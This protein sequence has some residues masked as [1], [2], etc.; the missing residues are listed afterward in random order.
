MASKGPGPLSIL[1]LLPWW[2][3]A[4]MTLLSWVIL[5]GAAGREVRLPLE[6]PRFHSE[7]LL[8]AKQCRTLRRRATGGAGALRFGEASV[9]SGAVGSAAVGSERRSRRAQFAGVPK[10]SFFYG[11]IYH[12]L[13]R[14]INA[15]NERF[16]RFPVAP[17]S[18]EIMQYSIYDSK[19]LGTYNWHEDVGFHS[20]TVARV[21]SVSV[22]VSS[23]ESYD[24][25]ELQLRYG[26]RVVNASKEVG[27]A[28]IFPSH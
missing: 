11:Q 20:E 5:W 16:W 18:L 23:A 9:G 17:G 7:Q 25:G 8:S 27:T 24:G 22:Q 12:R 19:D 13:W 14:F 21:L 26:D 3:A 1:D 10:E 6:Y 2:L 15:T 4:A 28:I